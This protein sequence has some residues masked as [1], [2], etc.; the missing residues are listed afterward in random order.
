M[1]EALPPD[2]PGGIAGALG[3]L[4][5]AL[6][7]PLS[8]AGVKLELLERRLAAA[9]SD[10]GALAERVRGV[11][12]DLAAAGRL[13]DLLPRLAA[14][15]GEA[16]VETSLGDLCRVAGIPVEGAPAFEPRLV[17]RRLATIDALRILV[18]FL[19]SRDPAGAPPLLYDDS[20]PGRLAL[21]IEA[22]GGGGEENPER[23]F[24]LP[25]GQERAGDLF[26]A[27][28]GIESDGGRLQLVERE[29]RLVALV[30][31][32]APAPAGE[33]GAAS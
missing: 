28:A 3:T 26:V 5:H 22:P 6:A 7:D 23:L 16:A 18:W 9:P 19:R 2:P 4:R 12:A 24:H 25:R 31:W 29:E 27:R 8:A 13:I 14:V 21:R 17:L 15:A 32:P 30:S 20:A 1:N 33:E 10:A 11:R